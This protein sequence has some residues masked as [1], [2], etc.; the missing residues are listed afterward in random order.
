MQTYG[1]VIRVSLEDV[2]SGIASYARAARC[3]ASSKRVR[4]FSVTSM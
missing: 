3:L 2:A 4:P 1:L